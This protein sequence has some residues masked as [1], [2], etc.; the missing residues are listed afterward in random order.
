MK[1]NGFDIK[2]KE[3]V[4]GFHSLCSFRR[5]RYEL[6]NHLGNVLAV[7]SDKRICVPPSGYDT[8]LYYAADVIMAQDYYPFGSQEPGRIWTQNSK[9]SFRYAFNN[10]EKD[11]EISGTG[12]SYAVDYWYYDPRLGRRWNIDQVVKYSLSPYSCFAVNPIL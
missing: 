2:A 11:D 8:T 1:G 4:L 12:N 6:T 5:K 3:K 10:Q 7:V 9:S